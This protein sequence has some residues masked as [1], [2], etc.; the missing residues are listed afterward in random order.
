[1]L[2]ADL[3]LRS[4]LGDASPF[5]R[6]RHAEMHG[7]RYRARVY[8]QSSFDSTKPYVRRRFSRQVRSCLRQAAPDS[9]RPQCSPASRRLEIGNLIFIDRVR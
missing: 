6:N 5:G 3:L 4:S 2:A 1:M 7:L 8:S 9:V